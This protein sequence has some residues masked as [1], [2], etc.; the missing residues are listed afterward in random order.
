MPEK[1]KLLITRRLRDAVQA[2]AA[3]DYQVLTNAEDRVFTREELI[4]KCQQVDAVLPCHSEHFSA[5]V[6]A[7]L[8]KSL[9]IIANH[10]VGVDHVDL[11]AAKDAGI[12]VTNTPDVLS[13]ATAEIAMLCMLGAARRGAEGDAMVRAGKWDFWSP[14][15][16]VGRQ[17]TGKRFGVLGMGRVGQVA[18]ER[19]RGFGMEV[20]YH[21]RK[22]LPDH[23]AKGAIFHETVEDLFAHSDVLSLHCPSTPETKG[24]INSKTIAMLPDRAILVNTARG[25]LV[26]EDALVAALQS[27]KLFAAGLDVFCNEPGG[28]QRISALN[29]VFLLPHIGSATEETRDA[30]GFRALDNLD[31]YFQGKEP[32]DRVA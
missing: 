28:N 30:M 22:P 13:D 21:N 2:R 11:A 23:L 24:I 4:E 12:V 1:P 25:N 26:D 6:I 10:S 31:A 29:N 27:G 15:F 20:H 9:K 8:P 18:A 3:R 7:E 19:A 32:G 17:V 14:A 16:M 5:D